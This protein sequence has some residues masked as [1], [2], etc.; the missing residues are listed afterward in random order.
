MAMHR[1]YPRR[2]LNALRILLTDSKRNL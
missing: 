2:V 1:K